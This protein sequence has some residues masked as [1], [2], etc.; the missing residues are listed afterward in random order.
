MLGAHSPLL[1]YLPPLRVNSTGARSAP[2]M[3]RAALLLLG[4]TLVP[5][6]ATVSLEVQR[7][8]PLLLDVVA[9]LTEALLGS[10]LAVTL[11]ARQQRPPALL[12]VAV[13]VLVAVLTAVSV[14][15]AVLMALPVA[16]EMAAA[17]LFGR[18]RCVR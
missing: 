7:R 15:V 10:Y 4:A 3:R 14:L 16:V 12:L 13:A 8:P 2:S 5:S 1:M 17:P 18:P 9:M 11:A 6:L